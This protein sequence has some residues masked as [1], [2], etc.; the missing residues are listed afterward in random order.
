V[1]TYLASLTQA[2]TSKYKITMSPFT[3]RILS[4]LLIPITLF[5]ETICPLIIIL[6]LA[7][8]TMMDKATMY[9]PTLPIS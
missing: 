3:H 6:L 5:K 9:F 1:G 8:K 4:G 7:I 2:I